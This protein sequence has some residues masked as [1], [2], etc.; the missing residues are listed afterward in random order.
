MKEVFQQEVGM[1][2][3]L[4]KD[5]SST[6][7]KVAVAVDAYI[8][9]TISPQVTS[10]STITFSSFHEASTMIYDYFLV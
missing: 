1:F 8:F 4:K 6:T 9:L 7:V 10:S 5:L 3:Q 2:G